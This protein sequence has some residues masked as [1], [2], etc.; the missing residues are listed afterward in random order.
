M[1]GGV[2][3]YKNDR[4]G[5]RKFLKNALK[6]TRSSFDGC[7][8]NG[9]LAQEVPMSKTTHDLTPTIFNSNK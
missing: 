4:G 2:H 3:P 6:G 1:Q 8:L 5:H 9:F 7:G